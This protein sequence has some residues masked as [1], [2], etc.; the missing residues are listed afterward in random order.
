MII[1]H[2]GLK[3]TVKAFTDGSFV[4]KN[5][6]VTFVEGEAELSIDGV[7][8]SSKISLDW[9]GSSY[10]KAKAAG[11]T[12][13][14]GSGVVTITAENVPEEALVCNVFVTN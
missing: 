13:T 8:A 5:Q 4:A 2:N 7:T 10:D 6:T 11:I 1:E 9:I 14:A 12:V 3:K